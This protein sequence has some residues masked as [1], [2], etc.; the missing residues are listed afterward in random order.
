MFGHFER[1]NNDKSAKEISEI[2]I[3]KNRGKSDKRGL[4]DKVRDY[5]V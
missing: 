4:L 5:V 3:K 2:I 1:R